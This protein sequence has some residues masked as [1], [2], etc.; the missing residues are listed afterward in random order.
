LAPR[1]LKSR[2]ISHL[3]YRMQRKNTQTRQDIFCGKDVYASKK[4]SSAIG[5]LLLYSRTEKMKCQAEKNMGILLNIKSRHHG[6]ERITTGYF[7]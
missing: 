3:L 7:R 6:N 5:Y 1:I 2:V 4:N